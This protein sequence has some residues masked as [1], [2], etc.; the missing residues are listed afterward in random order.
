MQI[1]LESS[2]DR[3]AAE[4]YDGAL[5]SRLPM[6]GHTLKHSIFRWRPAPGPSEPAFALS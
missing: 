1:E 2:L 4:F 3:W 5:F 6:R